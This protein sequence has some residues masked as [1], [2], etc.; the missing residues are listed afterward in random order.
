MARFVTPGLTWIFFE[1]HSIVFVVHSIENLVGD[2]EVLVAVKLS[3]AAE[4]S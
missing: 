4:L 3:F 2:I 1:N